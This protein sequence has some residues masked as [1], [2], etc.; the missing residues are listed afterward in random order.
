MVK[1]ILKIIGL[2]FYSLLP[3][4]LQYRSF[5]GKIKE[6]ITQVIN[7][8]VDAKVSFAEADLSLFKTFRTLLLISK[9]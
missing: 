4:Y 3:L 2:Y 6:K 1:K 9:I 5:Q 7:D 8:K